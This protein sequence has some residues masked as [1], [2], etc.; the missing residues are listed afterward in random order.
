M[1]GQNLNGEN[2]MKLRTGLG[3]I[4]LLLFALTVVGIL[5][6]RAIQV[7]TKIKATKMSL[8]FEKK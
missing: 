2:N 4:L 6:V 8:D 7:D 3:L 5:L 1:A